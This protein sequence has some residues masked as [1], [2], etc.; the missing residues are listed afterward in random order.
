[1]NAKNFTL[2]M[3]LKQGTQ[4]I[5]PTTRPEFNFSRAV[6]PQVCVAWKG[7]TAQKHGLGY[8]ALDSLF[9]LLFCCLIL[10]LS[11]SLAFYF[12]KSSAFLSLS[13]H[14]D[15]GRLTENVVLSFFLLCVRRILV[16]SY[17]I[18][19]TRPAARLQFPW[20]TAIM[21]RELRR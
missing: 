10:Y 21:L 8:K 1:M 3:A 14:P 5:R 18:Y 16:R 17:L 19:P 7:T 6:F 12:F 2:K 20:T 11:N 4:G 9:Y 13:P 15:D